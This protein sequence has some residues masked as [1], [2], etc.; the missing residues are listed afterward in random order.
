[1]T[2]LGEIKDPMPDIGL[3]MLEAEES[4]W[5][6]FIV[7]LKVDADHGNDYS[8]AKST[9]SQVAYIAAPTVRLLTTF[10]CKGQTAEARNTAEAEVI[11]LD[12][13][14]FRAGLPLCAVLPL[15]TAARLELSSDSSSA[16]SSLPLISTSNRCCPSKIISP[17]YN[18]VHSQGF[19]SESW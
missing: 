17:T 18:L 15:R 7:L 16:S 8:S 2:D 19:E 3:L 4:D 12:Y 6:R 10:G 11:A 1:M 5:E 9:S 13:G 14:T